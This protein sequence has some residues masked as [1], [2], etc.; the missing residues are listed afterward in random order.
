VRHRFFVKDIIGL[1]RDQN[2]LVP[3]VLPAD[4]PEQFSGLIALRQVAYDIRV[5]LY[6]FRKIEE[7]QRYDDC[8]GDDR[9]SPVDYQAGDPVHAFT[10][11]LKAA[12]MIPRMVA[13][14]AK[15]IVD[16]PTFFVF[17]S[18]AVKKNII[19]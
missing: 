14:E 2:D 12:T 5:D 13:Q 1:K 18:N 19:A 6:I 17:W 3:A 7:H 4:I 8:A 15:K 9:L 10:L 16:F 11:S